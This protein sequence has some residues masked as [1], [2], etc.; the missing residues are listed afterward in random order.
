MSSQQCELK[1]LEA[2]ES[3]ARCL[4]FYA[5]C[6]RLNGSVKIYVLADTLCLHVR[7]DIFTYIVCVC[8]SNE[9]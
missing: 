7:F 3:Q 5:Q 9:N 1:A 6:L 8:L 4:R 2:G